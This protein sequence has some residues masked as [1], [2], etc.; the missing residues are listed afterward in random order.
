MVVTYRMKTPC[1]Q[2]DINEHSKMLTNES[3]GG[4]RLNKLCMMGLAGMLFVGLAGCAN[5]DKARSGAQQQQINNAKPM[6][7]YSNEN[8]QNGNARVLDDNDGPLTEMMD[9]TLGAEGQQNNLNLQNRDENGNPPN[10]TVPLAAHDKNFFQRDNRFSTSDANYHGHLDNTIRKAGSSSNM[11]NIRRAA[12][13]V[14]NVKDV[15]SVAYGTSVVIAV[16]LIDKT[17]AKETKRRI[18]DAV[19]PYLGGKTCTV[20]VDEGTFSRNGNV[21]ND[22]SEGGA[23]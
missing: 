12:A 21:H 15:H 6:G 14:K 18:K 2:Q 1:P 22:I 19:K 8:H 9:H 17:R 23:R 10:P 13:S 3:G 4:F 20:I 16:D 11:N 7:Y 5:N